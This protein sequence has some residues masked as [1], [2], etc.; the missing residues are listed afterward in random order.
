MMKD[1]YT[2]SSKGYLTTFAA[3]PEI[4]ETKTGYG[5]E[6]RN[7]IRGKYDDFNFPLTFNKIKDDSGTKLR[8]VLDTRYPPAYLISDRMKSLLE[9]YHIT[10]WICYPIELYDKKNVLITGYHGFSITGRAGAMDVKNQ[11]IV[12]KNYREDGPI[13]KVYKGGFFD[14]DTWD[15]SDIFILDNSYWV[16]VTARVVELLKKHKITALEFER[17]SDKELSY[18]LFHKE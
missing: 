7:L 9:E 13:C 6:M 14:I 18:S 12:E 16:I 17:L 8:D 4:F 1:F 11:P 5:H 2:F 3:S 10:G 15:G